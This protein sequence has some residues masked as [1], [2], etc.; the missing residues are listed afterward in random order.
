MVHSDG[1]PIHHGAVDVLDSS[2]SVFACEVAH[3]TEATRRPSVGVQ[4]HDQPFYVASF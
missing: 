3:E 1:T 4:A 2:L